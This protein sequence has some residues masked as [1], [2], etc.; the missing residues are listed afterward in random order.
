MRRVLLVC[1]VLCPS[2]LMAQWTP[3]GGPEGGDIVAIVNA[4]SYLAC[5]ATDGDIFT[6]SN[7]GVQWVARGKVPATGVVV[8]MAAGQ[9]ALLATTFSGGTTAGLYRSTDEGATWTQAFFA[10]YCRVSANGMQVFAPADN[11]LFYSSNS[12]ATWNDVRGNLPLPARVAIVHGGAMFAGLIDSAVYRSTDNGIS[13]AR[14]WTEPLPSSVQILKSDGTT[15]YAAYERTGAA[16]VARSTDNGTSWTS[17][18]VTGM[19]RG[20]VDLL[21]TPAALYVPGVFQVGTAPWTA[22]VYVSTNNGS[23]WTLRNDGLI[24]RWTKSIAAAGSD[25]V[26]GT[27]GGGVFRS[28]NSGTAWSRSSGGLVKTWVNNLTFVSGGAEWYAGLLGGGFFASSDSG[29]TW[30]PRNSGFENVYSTASVLQFAIRGSSW[31]AG[32]EDDGL[33]K[34]T[35]NGASWSRT[36]LG[37]RVACTGIATRGTTDVFMTQEVTDGVYRSTDDGESW[38]QIMG[39]FTTFA[40][41]CVAI[42]GAGTVFV[43]GSAGNVLRTTNNGTNWF[44]SPLGGGAVARHLRFV[45]NTMFAGTTN[46]VY[47]STNFGVAWSPS[48][49]GMVGVEVDFIAIQD[50]ATLFA[51]SRD[52]G[53]YI[54]TNNGTTWRASKQGLP[55]LRL[56]GVRSTGK[57]LYVATVGYGMWRRPV[58]EVLTSTEEAEHPGLPADF[59]LEQNY[60]NPFNPATTIKFYLPSSVGTAYVTSL[61]VYDL[62]GREVA[63]LLNEPKAP[64]NHEVTWNAEGMASGV[65]F[66]KLRA[67]GVVQTRKM[68][69]AR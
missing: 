2:L 49:T 4:G 11:A 66:C 10:G 46:G 53:M 33:Y 47:R 3:L 18:Q 14:A 35:N 42:G 59:R 5:S 52:S 16:R 51:S 34:S 22:G 26:V 62:L 12:G 48:N 55:T 45:G 50:T 9:G 58:N 30:S 69:L 28:S 29:F 65:Y 36:F 13:W 61:R 7:N 40:A 38:D 39:G 54:S 31:F 63:M 41:T 19:P 20:I 25:V 8:Q 68:L 37:V 44:S 27:W 57:Y 67:G 21:V 24:P 17:S 60:P 56:R 23:S 1:T 32:T 64:G 15:L 43:G 6:S